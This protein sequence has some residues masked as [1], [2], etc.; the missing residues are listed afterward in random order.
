MASTIIT[1]NGT[2][3]AVPTSL[4]QGELAINV[5]SG[6]LYYGTSASG[7]MDASVSSSF[8][9]TSVSASGFISASSFSGD[10]SGLTNVTASGNISASGTI[11]GLSGS[12]ENITTTDITVNDDIVLNNNLNAGSFQ[13][14]DSTGNTRISA[15]FLTINR[16]DTG[17]IQ[18]TGGK[19]LLKSGKITL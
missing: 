14:S 10:G 9:F 5:S 1:K 12:F 19:I 13:I 3:S 17:K 8:T 2:G 6:Q 7:S 11:T 18:L 15:V 16:P 4:Q